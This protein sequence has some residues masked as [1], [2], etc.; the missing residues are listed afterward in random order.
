MGGNKIE[1]CS[2]GV[3]IPVLKLFILFLNL[4]EMLEYCVGSDG[5]RLEREVLPMDEH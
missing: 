3:N 2:I 1:T 4:D 5:L